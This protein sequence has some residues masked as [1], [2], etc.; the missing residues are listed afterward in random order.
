MT[1]FKNCNWSKKLEVSGITYFIDLLFRLLL[2]DEI[3]MIFYYLYLL[4]YCGLKVAQN[5]STENLFSVS[6]SAGSCWIQIGLN[7]ILNKGQRL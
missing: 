5:F 3:I 1:Y 4:L 7:T 2:I 6:M